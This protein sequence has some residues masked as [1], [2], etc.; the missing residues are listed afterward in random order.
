MTPLSLLLPTL[1]PN[2]WTHSW[3]FAFWVSSCLF[4]SYFF[5]CPPF[6][7]TPGAIPKRQ[8]ADFNSKDGSETGIFFSLFCFQAKD[9]FILVHDPPHLSTLSFFFW[10]PLSRQLWPKRGGSCEQ[11]IVCVSVNTYMYKCQNSTRSP[12]QT[13]SQYLSC[14]QNSDVV[15]GICWSY[16]PTDTLVYIVLLCLQSSLLCD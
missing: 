7:P 10:E 1:P 9:R 13:R 6:S 15:P 11:H 4:S 5:K 16:S 14:Y 12:F 3:L 2:T 8:V